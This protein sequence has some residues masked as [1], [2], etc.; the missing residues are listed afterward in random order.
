MV[1]SQVILFLTGRST[2][3]AAGLPTCCQRLWE[4]TCVISAARFIADFWMLNRCLL[5]D[6][7]YY[8]SCFTTYVN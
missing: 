6:F 4:D 8:L 5:L 1:H 3:C 7:I 2:H